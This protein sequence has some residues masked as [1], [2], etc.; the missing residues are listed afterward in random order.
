VNP[1]GTT[2]ASA[3]PGIPTGTVGQFNVKIHG[4]LADVVQQHRLFDPGPA[5]KKKRTVPAGFSEIGSR[6]NREEMPRTR[7]HS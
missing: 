7:G 3:V 4:D 2:S 5:L 6:R 1:N